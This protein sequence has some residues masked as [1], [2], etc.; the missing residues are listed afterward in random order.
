MLRNL[1]AVPSPCRGISEDANCDMKT[2]RRSGRYR[3]L[4]L[5]C[6]RRPKCTVSRTISEQHTRQQGQYELVAYFAVWARLGE[7]VRTRSEQ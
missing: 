2:V 5:H 1:L 7:Y 4:I 3:R 6:N